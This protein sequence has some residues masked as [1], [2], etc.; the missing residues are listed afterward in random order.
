MY[1]LAQI[2]M[3]DFTTR[4]AESLSAQ[5]ELGISPGD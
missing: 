2:T 4:L 5:L 1:R 3:N